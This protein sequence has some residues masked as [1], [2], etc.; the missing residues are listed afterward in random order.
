M[1]CCACDSLKTYVR[2][3]RVLLH[4]RSDCDESEEDD[5][6]RKPVPEWARGAALKEQLLRQ[7]T[8]DPDEIFQ[9]HKKTCA[10][11]EVFGHDGALCRLRD[12][13]MN[14]AVLLCVPSLWVVTPVRTNTPR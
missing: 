11:N 1:L 13:R 3:P 12:G 9:Q 14:T 10:L 6:P 8:I 5:E 4:V 7:L 2:C